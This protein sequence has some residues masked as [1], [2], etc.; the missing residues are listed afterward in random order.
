MKLIIGN[1]NYSSWSLRAWLLPAVHDL[2]FE[3]V[4]VALSQQNTATEIAGYTDA[5]K[6]PVLHDKDLVIW[7]SLAICEYISER[8]LDGR[9]WPA[10]AEARAV[11]RSCSA[12]MHSGF[13]A[14]REQ[15]PMN[16]RATNREVD[17]SAELQKDI[18]RIDSLWSWLRQRYSAQG[19]WLFGAFSIVDCMFAPVVFRFNTYN[20]EVSGVSRKYME[21]V[22]AQPKV[23]L[24]REQA[25]KEKEIIEED[26]AGC[27]SVGKSSG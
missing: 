20:I 7:D 26:E 15:M 10:S 2:S 12:E 22:L 25:K 5:G 23:Q 3:E 24:W 18:S 14:L 19:S 6:V 9:G 27:R 11:A 8:Y 17:I 21:H 4:R 13:F 1:K 16:C